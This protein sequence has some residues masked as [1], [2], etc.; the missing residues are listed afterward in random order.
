ML[1][2]MALPPEARSFDS[3][4]TARSASS[5]SDLANNWHGSLPIIFTALSVRENAPITPGVFATFLMRGGNVEGLAFGHG[6]N[7]QAALFAR[8]E[9]LGPTDTFVCSP[10]FLFEVVDGHATEAANRCLEIA[11]RFGVPCLPS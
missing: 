5:L 3:D 4:Q 1:C 10:Y 6:V 7:I 9:L 8:L 2:A 11:M